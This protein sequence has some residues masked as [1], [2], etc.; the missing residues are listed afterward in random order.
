MLIGYIKNM[1]QEK[2]SICKICGYPVSWDQGIRNQ[3]GVRGPL[4]ADK[5]RPHSCPKQDDKVLVRPGYEEV[6]AKHRQEY[7]AKKGI[8]TGASNTAPA[9]APTP[10]LN[11]DQNQEPSSAQQGEA[12]VNAIMNSSTVDT[13]IKIAIAELVRKVEDIKTAYDQKFAELDQWLN[14]AGA[15]VN[16]I[17]KKIDEFI[18]YNPTERATLRMV[19]KLLTYLPEPLEQPKALSAEDE[20]AVKQPGVE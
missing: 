11:V 5:S 20:A 14:G 10:S 19:E 9:A 8:T 15:M 18:R 3:F 1:S 16:G 12:A 4:E 2:E 13:S 6:V 7:L 17:D